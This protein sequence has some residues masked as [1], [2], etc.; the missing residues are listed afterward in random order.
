MIFNSITFAIFLPI[1]FIIYWLI[2]YLFLLLSVLGF[3][4]NK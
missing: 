3:V 4:V 1:V 2:D